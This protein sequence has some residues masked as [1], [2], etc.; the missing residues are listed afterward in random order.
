M[1]YE[2]LLIE[3]M[4]AATW[5]CMK[6]T[7]LNSLLSE[8]SGGEIVQNRQSFVVLATVQLFISYAKFQSNTKIVLS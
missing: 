8:M 3:G 1:K 4:D 7:I 6:A 2:L 5:N